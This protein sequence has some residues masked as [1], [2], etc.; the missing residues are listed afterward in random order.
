MQKIKNLN[1]PR[2]S[3][4]LLIILVYLFIVATMLPFRQVGFLDDFSFHHS[5]RNLVERG[6]LE[7]NDWAQP[8]LISQVY[9]GALFAKLF[10]FQ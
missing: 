10:A 8:S 7:I 9:W 4:L 2:I 6:T 3:G 5:V 1:L